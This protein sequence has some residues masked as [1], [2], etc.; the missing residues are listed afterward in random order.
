MQKITPFLWFNNQAEEAANLYVSIFK[1]SKILNVSR[2]D[3]AGA[4][5]SGRP[6]GT[7]MVVSFELDGQTF[8]AINGGPAFTFTEAVS[9][10]ISCE[11]QA[12]VD[13]YWEKL[14]TGGSEGQCGW[15]KDAYG[16]S[17]QVVTAAMAKLMSN[18]IV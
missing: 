11:D 13:Y 10:V 3:E 7:A 1:N 15:L 8:N 9:F 18:T 14:S 12:E 16:L 6:A 17:W 4:S 2:Y 5:A